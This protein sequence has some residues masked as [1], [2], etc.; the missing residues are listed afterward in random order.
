MTPSDDLLCMFTG[1]VKELDGSYYVEIPEQEVEYGNIDVGSAVSLS[2]S[3]PQTGTHSN[4]NHNTSNNSQYNNL[5]PPV[6]Q[7]DLREVEIEDMGDQGDGI[8]RIDG[9]VVIVPDTEIGDE[10]NVRIKDVNTDYA[11]AVT[12][13]EQESSLNHK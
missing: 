8:A 6:E 10:I 11:Y 12:E 5:E 9:Y 4:N 13:T 2:V 3:P 1:K 7:G